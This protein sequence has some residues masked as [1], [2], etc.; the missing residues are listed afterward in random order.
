MTSHLVYFV[1]YN[2]LH[3][4][5]RDIGLKF[6][7]PSRESVEGLA[8]RDVVNEDDTLRTT[9]IRRGNRAETFLTRCILKPIEST[10]INII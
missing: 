2:D 3:D 9:I 6:S 5:R 8:I 4:G 7:I 10:N 1:A